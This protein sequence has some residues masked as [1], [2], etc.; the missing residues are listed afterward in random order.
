MKEGIEK[1]PT[2]K[3]TRRKFLF[4]TAVALAAIGLNT[5]PSGREAAISPVKIEGAENLKALIPPEHLEIFIK[6]IFPRIFSH[7][8]EI[9]KK[10]GKKEYDIS[11]KNLYHVHRYFKDEFDDPTVGNKLA[12]REND[13]T[14]LYHAKERMNDSKKRNIFIDNKGRFE[15]RDGGG[16]HPEGREIVQID[17]ADSFEEFERLVESGKNY[18]DKNSLYKLGDIYFAVSNMNYKP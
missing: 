17:F 18:F 11:L 12:T 3:I 7:L 2:Q 10:L 1:G 15:T 4:N 6:K 9:Q 14:Y 13:L 5:M 8:K 16:V